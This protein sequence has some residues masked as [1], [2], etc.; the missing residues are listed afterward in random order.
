M[1]YNYPTVHLSLD[2]YMLG[3]GEQKVPAIMYILSQAYLM[4]YHTTAIIVLRRIRTSGLPIGKIG[5]C[6]SIIATALFWAWAETKIMANPWVKDQF[7]YK[8]VGRMLTYG[9]IFYACYFIP[10]FP[11][12]YRID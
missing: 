3:T 8:N 9:S 7:T 1:I 11:I 5:W 6:L 10:S 12:F 4:T 2:S